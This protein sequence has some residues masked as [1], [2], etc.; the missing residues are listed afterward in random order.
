MSKTG[1]TRAQ[2]KTKP[3]SSLTLK[4][5]LEMISELIQYRYQTQYGLIF[6]AEIRVRQLLKK[7]CFFAATGHI[8]TNFK[9]WH[10]KIIKLLILVY[11][12]R[13]QFKL[14][15]CCAA[16]QEAENTLQAGNTSFSYLEPL[17]GL[18]FTLHCKHQGVCPLVEDL[19]FVLLLLLA[20]FRD[21]HDAAAW[22]DEFHLWGLVFRRLVAL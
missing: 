1:N 8:L 12:L 19:Q 5:Q 16:V 13:A 6:G 4:R 21:V 15:A 3:K 11:Y 17:L 20:I 18:F 9:F 2:T 14:M 22:Q 7:T 10:Y